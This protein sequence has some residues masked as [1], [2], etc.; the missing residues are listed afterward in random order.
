MLIFLACSSDRYF[1]KPIEIRKSL[2]KSTLCQN[3]WM[4]DSIMHTS[5]QRT[6]LAWLELHFC[7]CCGILFSLGRFTSFTEH[8]QQRPYLT[9]TFYVFLSVYIYNRETGPWRVWLIAISAICRAPF[10]RYVITG[11][12]G[13]TKQRD[14]RK[15][16]Q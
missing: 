16:W 7:R 14:L 3:E 1:L 13:A 15:Q 2:K 8:R 9:K 5:Y 4:M 11:Y 10:T 6:F 12:E